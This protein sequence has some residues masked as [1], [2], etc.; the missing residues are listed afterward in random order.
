[1]SASNT[2]LQNFRRNPSLILLVT[3]FFSTIAYAVLYSTLVL[4]MTQKLHL[5]SYAA[6]SIMGLFLAFNYV[7][8]L[9]GAFMGGNLLSYRNLFIIGMI[10]QIVACALFS[11]PSLYTL[12]LALAFYLAGSGLNVPCINMM[13]TQQFKPEDTHRETAFIWNYAGM[14][15]GF[16]L[17]FT[18]AG[19]F[20]LNL[21]YHTLFLL[22]IGTNVLAIIIIAF[23]WKAVEDHTTP[24]SFITIKKPKVALTRGILGCIIIGIIILGLIVLL[25]YAQ[26]TNIIILTI[27]AAMFLLFIYLALIQ[28]NIQDRKKIFVYIILSLGGLVF[29]S[30]YQLAPMGLTLFTQ[31]NV[32][33]KMDGFSI[34]P[35]W[36]PN[37]NT[38]II[39]VGGIL[40]PPFFK[41]IRRYI[42]FSYP[43]QFACSLSFIAFGYLVLPIGIKLASPQGYVAF[44]WI[45]LSYILQSI[46]ELFIGPIGYAM[47]GQLATRK[48]QGLMMGAWMLIS[49][50]TSG[51]IA[52]YLSN[53]AI[54]GVHSNNPLHTNPGYSHLFLGIGVISLF[55]A[56]ILFC[57]VP[58]LMRM[59]TYVE[60]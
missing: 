25:E 26:T 41:K 9:L 51:V 52:S 49:G 29:W 47:I 32:D 17:G 5:S 12:F 22:T 21:D 11:I 42:N 2:S 19:Y 28:E 50:G 44:I 27:G 60:K 20:Q 59:I 7:L 58:N 40:L 35:Q 1:M 53:Y 18:V 16:L 54:R 23:G 34:P 8:H 31:Y 43:L 30:L 38:I 46:G 10:I 45:A 48:L 13:L 14:N 57:L 15:V 6:N 56:F 3:Q 24:L 39:A 37:I 33:R 55:S 36:I 4:Y